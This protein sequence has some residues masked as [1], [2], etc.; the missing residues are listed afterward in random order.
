V[1]LEPDVEDRARLTPGSPVGAAAQKRQVRGRPES[2]LRA[3]P[4]IVQVLVDLRAFVENTSLRSR[5]TVAGGIQKNLVIRCD[6]LLETQAHRTIVDSIGIVIDGKAWGHRKP[7]R[8]FQS[9]FEQ[10][11]R[12]VVG[13]RLGDPAL[14]LKLI[15]QG[16]EFTR[17]PANFPLV[18]RGVNLGDLGVRRGRCERRSLVGRLTGQGAAVARPMQHLGLERQHLGILRINREKLVT[19]LLSLRIIPAIAAQPDQFDSS[20]PILRHGVQIDAVLLNGALG[21]AGP[22]VVLRQTELKTAILR[23]ESPHF[24]QYG[25]RFPVVRFHGVG[26]G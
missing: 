14:A 5:R 13:G 10:L 7:N 25:N 26:A 4:K 20:L 11:V 16:R 3:D 6:G 8:F 19:E 21:V 23:A 15:A 12:V 1:G 22:G 18:K 2:K 17:G 24:L 9:V